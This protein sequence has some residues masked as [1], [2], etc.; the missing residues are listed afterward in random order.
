MHAEIFQ[1]ACK[2]KKIERS[3]ISSV[4][5][6][7]LEVLALCKLSREAYLSALGF[8]SSALPWT[9]R[10]QY[11]LKPYAA[12]Q[13]LGVNMARGKNYVDVWPCTTSP[14]LCGNGFSAVSLFSF[15]LC[16]FVHLFIQCEAITNAEDICST[17]KQF[18]RGPDYKL[19]LADA[20]DKEA[21]TAI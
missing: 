19:M 13:P 21:N 7:M 4:P 10:P 17:A 5:Q 2:L 12:L 9:G 15:A 18:N 1:S 6:W 8:L 16:H 14:Q 20:Q 11:C 3:P